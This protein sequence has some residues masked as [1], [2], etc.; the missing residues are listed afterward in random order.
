[1]SESHAQPEQLNT[2]D[3]IGSVMGASLQAARPRPRDILRGLSR[4]RRTAALYGK[5]HPV[6]GRLIADLLPIVAEL[7]ANRASLAIFIH[8]ET[9]FVDNTML[10]EESVQLFPLLADLKKRKI[11]QVELRSGLEADELRDFVDV[12]NMPAADLDHLGGAAR[13]LGQ[14]SVHHI[15]V[16]E[17]Q[18]GMVLPQAR[19]RI[20]P[21][22]AYRAGLHVMD[23]MYFQASRDVT[24]DLHKADLI[25]NSLIELL[26][27]DKIGLMGAATIKKYDEDTAHHSVNVCILSLLMGS[28]LQFDPTL[29]SA[30]GLAALLHDIGKVRIP[31]D[32]LR[33]TG[34]FTHADREIMKR[35]TVHGAQLLRNLPGKAR[36]GMIVAFEHHANYDLS[37][38][39]D[40]VTKEH[41]HIL[42]R[43]VQ[44]VDAFDA[45]TSSR[46]IYRRPLAPDDAMRFILE[47]AGTIF[48]PELARVFLSTMGAYPVGTVVR[49]NTGELA[50]VKLPAERDTRQPTVRVFA[51]SDA[52]PLEPYDVVL[53]DDDERRIVETLDPL[54][55]GV[56]V[57]H[58]LHDTDG[59]EVHAEPLV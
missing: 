12:L 1:M 54:E 40:I 42:S 39:P 50:V 58:V 53:E 44:I 55:V 52:T 26:T 48:D 7:L 17:I 59:A 33:K 23:E 43:L 8:E 49:L 31:L 6:I 3:Q 14:H 21:T 30:L 22:D 16:G 4:V 20:D 13:Y 18:P 5:D 24:L 25:V 28:R 35:H 46:R 51:D 45:A 32:V 2:P 41:P 11:L 47:G 34:E 29:T 10:L 37:G 15:G 38:Y 36:L 57:A 9:F 19:P 27:K 56:D